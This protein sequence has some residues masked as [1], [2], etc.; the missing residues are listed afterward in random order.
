MVSAG[1]SCPKDGLFY[2]FRFHM[3]SEFDKGKRSCRKR[4]DGHNRRRRKPQ[5]DMMNLRGFFP[6]HQGMYISID[7]KI[8]T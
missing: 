8:G 2:T 1:I 5:H 3:L 6:Y 7:E 4:L